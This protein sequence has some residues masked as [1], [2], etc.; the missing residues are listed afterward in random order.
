MSVKYR[1]H[2][3]FFIR[4]GWLS[5]G[6][7]NILKDPAVFISRDAN[8]MDTLG[9]GSNMVKS[10]RYWMQAVGL[11]QE[12]GERRRIQE[13]TQLG[14]LIQENDPYME[15][16]GTLWLLHYKLAINKDEATAWYF[17][18]NEFRSVEFTRDDFVAQTGNYLRELNETIA[19]RSIDDDYNCIINTYI[20]RIKSNPKRFDPEDNID[21][22]LGELGLIDIVNKKD[23][24]YKKSS[25][26]KDMLHPLILLA[27]IL[28]QANGNKEIR[29][30]EIQTAKC[31]A[32]KVF[33]LDIIALTTLLY[34]LE[35]LKLIKVVR[36]AG[37][38]VILIETDLTFNGCI[39][40]Y[41][42]SINR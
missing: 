9:I 4:R 19:E 20:P 26:K 3:T 31:N 8:P 11:A 10:L 27:V 42:R 1:A 30:S 39:Q 37:L 22:P 40:E 13:L 36:T 24:V 6:V 7:K 18:F 2:D 38:D 5:K 12:A 16:L 29:I 41:Y 15:E 33:N 17:F 28:D 34:K 32:G 23:K 14:H 35:I 21:C 25:P